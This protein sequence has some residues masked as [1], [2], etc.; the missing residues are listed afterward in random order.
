MH[1]VLES[2]NNGKACVVIVLEVAL[3]N[4]DINIINICTIPYI[5]T[6]VLCNACNLYF[7]DNVT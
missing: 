2:L 1:S 5:F 4:K 7:I 6:D 3:Y